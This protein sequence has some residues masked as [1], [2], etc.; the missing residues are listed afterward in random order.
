MS[1][2]KIRIKIDKTDKKIV[3]LLNKRMNLSLKVAE[4]KSK[5]NIPVMN[6]E[7]EEQILKTVKSADAEYGDCVQNIYKTILD[8]SRRLQNDFIEESTN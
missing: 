6:E 8:E 5:E 2:D 3:Q 7:R 1:L 4:I